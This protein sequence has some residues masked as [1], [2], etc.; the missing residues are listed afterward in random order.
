MAEFY[1]SYSIGIDNACG[2]FQLASQFHSTQLKFLSFEFILNNYE[3]IKKTKS[4]SKLEKEHF[5]EILEGVMKK[6]PQRA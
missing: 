6:L 5:M 3:I 2:I 1:L 4:F